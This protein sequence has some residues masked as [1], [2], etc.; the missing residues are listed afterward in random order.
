[1]LIKNKNIQE[2][3]PPHTEKREKREH[4]FEM[5]S[6]CQYKIHKTCIKK[7]VLEMRLAISLCFWWLCAFTCKTVELTEWF[8]KNSLTWRVY[9]FRS[10]LT[11][12]VYSVPPIVFSY[13][14]NPFFYLGTIS[15]WSWNGA[16]LKTNTALK[17][18]YACHR[19]AWIKIV[20]FTGVNIE[21]RSTLG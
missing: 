8:T 10:P 20:L 9:I 11:F 16:C 5:W 13:W 18:T 17:V 19:L 7:R 21:F 12:L 14:V 6:S 15:R 1:V 4:E 3:V 2:T